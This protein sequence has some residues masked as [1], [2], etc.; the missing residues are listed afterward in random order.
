LLELEK[1]AQEPEPNTLPVLPAKNIAPATPGAGTVTVQGVDNLLVQ[2]ARCCQPLPGEAIVGYLTRSRGVSVH[3]PDCT[4]F[5]R[6][7]GKEPARVLPVEWGV[8]RSGQH[9]AIQLD[10]IDRKWLLKDITTLVAQVGVH[11]LSMQSEQTRS[12]VRV[13]LQARIADFEQLG[14]LLARLEALPGVATAR[15]A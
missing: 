2:V 8:R 7:A 5:L 13:R 4:A 14:L 6:L 9:V 3:R 15:R 12:G 1:A 10:G 11:V